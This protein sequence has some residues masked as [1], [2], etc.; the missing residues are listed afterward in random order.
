MSEGAGEWSWPDSLD[1]L[2]AAPEHHRL[3]FEND[4]V[5]VLDTFIEPGETA[6][7]HT[8]RWPSVLFAVTSDHVVR[9]DAD[10]NVLLD[11]RTSGEVLA[12]GSAIWVGQM[13]PHSVENVGD[14]AIRL[15]N[16]ELKRL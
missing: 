5:R 11:S 7:L 15:L 9:R 10:G 4:E 3:V 6:P 2:V 16:I 13:A 8:H 14:S 1:A 12:S